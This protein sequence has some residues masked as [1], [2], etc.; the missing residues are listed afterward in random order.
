MSEA[1]PNPDSV[2]HLKS[3]SIGDGKSYDDEEDYE[4]EMAD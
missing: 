2:K 4:S 1:S 3:D